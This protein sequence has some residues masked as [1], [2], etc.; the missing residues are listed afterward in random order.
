MKLGNFPKRFGDEKINE[1]VSMKKEP[2][3]KKVY[4]KGFTEYASKY[5]NM[6]DCKKRF[7]AITES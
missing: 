7:R 6:S 5:K 3:L 1:L 2:Y 4:S